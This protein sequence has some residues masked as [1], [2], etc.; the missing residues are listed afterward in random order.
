MTHSLWDQETVSLVFHHVTEA[1][2]FHNVLQ[3]PKNKPTLLYFYALVTE[4][5]PYT[6][7]FF[8]LNNESILH[9]P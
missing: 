3:A 2:S 4:Y 9:F 5:C 8:Y 7:G 6:R 1:V